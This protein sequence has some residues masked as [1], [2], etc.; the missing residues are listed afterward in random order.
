MR[1][2]LIPWGSGRQFAV[3]GTGLLTTGSGCITY[4]DAYET[5]GSAAASVTLFDG[6]NS[7][8]QVMI[9]YQLAAGQSTSEQ[10]GLHWMPYYQGLY[11]VTNNGAAA[12]SLSTWGDHDC[13]YHLN[14]AFLAIESAVIAQAL[15][16]QGTF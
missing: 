8:G 14:T 5:S 15:A 13:A 4:T 9:D 16:N 12:G 7:N 3:T 2:V 6:N 10:W 1:R 11:I